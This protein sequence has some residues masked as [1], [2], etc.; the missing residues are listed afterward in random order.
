[1]EQYHQAE[2]AAISAPTPAE[3]LDAGSVPPAAALQCPS[4]E[5]SS[6]TN[7]VQ[8]PAEK[9]A[10]S[11]PHEQVHAAPAADM[12]AVNALASPPAAA[13]IAEEGAIVAAVAAEKDGPTA[14]SGPC[15]EPEARLRIE[16]FSTR[17]ARLLSWFVFGASLV[18]LGATV[19]LVCLK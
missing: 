17:E 2:Q 6:H 1:M 18:L 10:T 9:A 12:P 3:M 15:A 4:V 5:G 13:P 16:Y 7:K 14:T 11:R 8:Q 19:A